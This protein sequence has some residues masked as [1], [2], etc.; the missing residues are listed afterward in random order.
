MYAEPFV[1]VKWFADPS[2]FPTQYG[3]LLT[4]PLLAAFAVALGAVAAAYLVQQRFPEPRAVK[5]LERFSRTGPLVLGLHLGIA[6][7]AAAVVGVL[8][9]P[10]LR[11][12]DDLFG[13]AILVIEAVCGIMILL[14]LATRAAA[15]L[16][17][18]LGIVAMQPFNFESI[19][20]NVHILGIA[21]FLFIVGRG[22]I[23]LD[24]IRR[25]RPPTAHADA[26]V[27]ALTLLR[28]ALGFA[29]VFG[30]L[31][32]KLLNPGLAQSLL[33]EMPFMNVARPFGI[34][35][36]QFAYLVGVTELAIGAVILSGQLTR[37]AAAV[38]AAIFTATLVIF[39]WSELLGHLPFYGILFMLFI[40]PNAD[41]WRVR[42]GLRPRS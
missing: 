28:L 8:F 34:G 9:V 3:L 1:H 19:L 25:V 42:E 33:Q 20:E 12:N 37:P 10:A 23:S 13:R 17:V 31:T 35:D 7:L 26:P 5:V 36:P 11:P 15:I 21:V 30:A 14:G 41:S 32:E 6:L 39:G 27:A 18:L 24:R 29:I 16:L 22:P 4:L 38:G 40:A 2:R